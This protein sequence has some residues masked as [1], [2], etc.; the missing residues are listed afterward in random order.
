[1]KNDLFQQ[2][3]GGPL[4]TSPL[5][6]LINICDFEHIRNIFD[7]FHYKKAHMGGGISFCMSLNFKNRVLGGAVIG[8]PRHMKKYKNLLEI[9]R[10]ALID[11]APKN[12]ESYFL[13]KILWWIKK[14]KLASGVI[15]Y[16]DMSV[17]HVGT[18]Y[19]AA[20]FKLVGETSESKHVFW[21]GR[22]YHPRS[23]TIDRPYSFE[24]RKA[25]ESGEAI[26]ET[27]KPKKIFIYNFSGVTPENA[28]VQ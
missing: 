12:C 22:R 6:C 11:E 5:Q 3:D 2:V 16:S 23:L 17:G 19:K 21:N 7:R 14:N 25:I 8:L 26:L 13:S 15:S 10:M 27:G 28:D 4:P 24:L 18:I 20:N 9:R 1:M